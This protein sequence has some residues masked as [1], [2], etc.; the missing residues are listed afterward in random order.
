MQTTTSRLHPL[1][2][3]AAISVIVLSA[4]GV[5][6]LSGA[7]PSSKG[8][9]NALELPEGSSRAGSRRRLPTRRETAAKKSV[10]HK[11]APQPLRP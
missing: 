4:V 10:V 8:Q 2:T 6:T 11:A 5:A 1:L 7:I 3:A 9:E